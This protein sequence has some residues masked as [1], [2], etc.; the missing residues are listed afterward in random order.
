MQDEKLKDDINESNNFIMERLRTQNYFNA[1]RIIF[2]LMV[3][4]YYGGIIWFLVISQMMDALEHDENYENRFSRAFDLESKSKFE[5]LLT[6]NY[7]CFTT[8]STVGLG[9]LY[10]VSPHE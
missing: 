10:P 4:L 6:A 7:F 9:D 1:T 3:I 8:V 5:Q 2:S